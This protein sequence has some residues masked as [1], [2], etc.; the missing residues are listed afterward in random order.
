MS[1][2]GNVENIYPLSPMQEGML[3]HTLYAPESGAYLRQLSWPIESALDLEA[4]HRAWSEVV[5]RHPILRTAFLWEGRDRPLQ[6]VRRQVRLHLERHDWRGLSATEQAARLAELLESDRR[7]SFDLVRAPLLR[8]RL[9]TLAE[10]S[11]YL[12]WSY[13]QLLLDGWSR[14]QVLREVMDLYR[15][16]VSGS[17]PSL[18]LARPFGE[19]IAWLERQDRS[20][21]E[22]YWRQSLQG[23]TAPMPLPF[24]RDPED[25]TGEREGDGD[26][27]L[28]LAVAATAALKA[29]AR[30][31]RLTLNAAVQGAWS[32]LLSRYSGEPEVLFGVTVSG[33]PADLPG[34][35]SMVGLFINTLPLRV[36]VPA[37][38][39][40][41][42]WLRR[43]QDRQSEMRQFEYSPLVDIQG[44]SEVPRGRAL[45]D[46]IMVFENYLAERGP[47]GSQ[48]DGLGIGNVRSVEWLGFP[49]ILVAGPGERLLLRV[50]YESQ[51]FDDVAILRL[52]RHLEALLVAF[53]EDPERRLG[54]LDFLG[55]GERHQL[56]LEWNDS[57]ATED[58]A[59]GVLVPS[60]FDEQAVRTPDR[61]AL[62]CGEEALTY[63]ALRARVDETALRLQR[64][65]V[66]PDVPVGLFLDRSPE[67]VVGLLGVLK[68]G[69]AY[70]SLDPDLPI[71]RLIY[72]LRDSGL[73]VVLTT[74][75]LRT[76]VPAGEGCEVLCL[77]AGWSG[78]EKGPASVV[79]EGHLAYLIYTSGT[80]GRPK[81]VM[82][83]HRS[84]ANVLLA[85]RRRFGW[86]AG[87]R[88]PVL[89]PSSFDIFLFELLNPLLAGG[90]CD[91]IPLK[92]VLDLERLAA[93]LTGATRFHAVPALM[94][95]I[96]DQARREGLE[97]EAFGG[98][99]SIFVGGD[100]VPADLLTAMRETFPAEIHV[101]YG[102]TEGTVICSSFAV[103]PAGRLRGGLIGRPLEN[104]LLRV[105]D[106]HE[107]PASVGVPGELWI[108][109]AGVARG[110]LGREELTAEKYLTREGRRYYRTG[111][112]VRWLP[113]GNLEFLGRVDQQVKIRGFRVEPGEIEA[114]LREHP[115]VAEAAVVASGDP[116][117]Y[118]R[119]L[120]YVVP[121][122]DSK[123]EMELWPSSGEYFVYDE[124]TYHGLTHDLRR[125]EGYLRALRRHVAGKV[126]VDVG[127]GRDAIQARLCIEAGAERVYAIEIVEETC[128]QA[129]KCIHAL[130]LSDRI[131]VIHGNALEVE[132][133]ERVDVCVSEIVE[134]IAG[135]EGAAII[136]NGA[137]RFL[138]DG[139]VMIPGRCQTLIAAAS[140][141]NELL[142][143]PRF[144]EVSGHYVEMIFE[145][146]GH[147]F[148]LRL[149]IK[150]FPRSRL[151]ST[152]GV[153]EDLDF[154]GP[155]DVEYSRELKL[156]VERPGRMDGFLAWLHMELVPGEVIDILE[157]PYSWLPVYFPVFHP[158]IEV[159]EGDEIRAICRG[160]LSENGVNPDYSLEGSIVG[161]GGETLDFRF[162]SRRYEKRYK[163]TP[164]YD[165]L[166]R[167]GPVP[168]RRRGPVSDLAPALKGYLG[169]RLPEYMV[170]SAFVELA[171]LPLTPHGKVDRRALAERDLP[172]T[173]ER[174]AEEAPRNWIEEI[175]VSTW[176]QVLGR[177]PVGIH[178]SFFDLGGHSLL[179]TQAISRLRESFRL[180]LPLA[181]LFAAPSVAGF[182]RR[183]ERELE[184]GS[185]VSAPPIVPVPRDRDLPLSFA[186]QRLWFLHE[187]EPDSPVY[188]VPITLR[189]AGNLDR[190]VL[191][192]SLSEVVRRHEVL[193][194]TFEPRASGAVQVIAPPGSV[195]L[196]LVDLCCLVPE[197]RDGEVWHLARE[198]AR[199]PLNL[200]HGPLLRIALL[201]LAPFEHVLL[202][203]LHHV[204]CDGW[205]IGILVRELAAL[206]GA[207]VEGRAAR[208]PELPVQYAD[209]ALWQ[210]EWLQG[211]VL[212]DLL[213]YWTRQLGTSPAMLDLPTDRPRPAVQT[214]R[215]A[216]RRMEL[217]A[218]LSQ[219]LYDL[220]RRESTTP[221]M[222]LLAVYATLLG[223][224][225]VQD[226]IILGTPI[227]GRNRAEIEGL[228]GF[229]VNT[230]ALRIDLGGN[231]PFR[232]LAA[233]VREVALGAY[234]GQD[235]PFDR[236]VEELGL[237]RDLG[238][239]PLF[240]T[241][242]VLQ[243]FPRQSFELPALELHAFP[244][245]GETAKL[246]LTLSMS[247]GSEGIAGT[248][249]YST[250][251]FDAATAE[252]LLGH[253]RMLLEAAV[254]DPLARLSE[255]SMMSGL[256][257]HQLLVE[258]N[259]SPL[260]VPVRPVHELFEMQARRTPDAPAVVFPG[261]RLSYAQLD[262]RADRLAA[263]LGGR[264][265]APGALVA[266]SAERS[267]DMIVALLGILKAG[268]AYVPLDPSYP[269]ERLELMI[270][271]SQANLLVTQRAL[272][273]GLLAG[274]I[275]LMLLEDEREADAER[276]SAWAGM[277]AL[278][279][280]AYVVY[281]SGSTGRPKGILVSHG[282]LATRVLA[283][284]ETYG[285]GPGRRMLQFL[286][287]SFDAV[288]EEIYP[289]LVSGG[290]L[291]MLGDPAAIPPGE[292]LDRAGELGA[293]SFHVPPSYWYQILD[294]FAATGRNIPEHV[295]LFLTGGESTLVDKL[296]AWLR[297]SRHPHRFFNVYGPSEATIS[298]TVYQVPQDA[299][300]VARLSRL[301]IGRVVPY[302]A[303]YVLSPDGG[304][305]P[306]G[307]PG[308]L[309]LGDCLADGYLGRPDLTAERFV[310][311]PVGPRGDRLYRTGDL[312][313]RL[314]DGHLEY[315]GRLDF[316]V[317]IRGFRVELG[318]IEAA[319]AAHPGVRQAAVTAGGES[320]ERRLVAYVVPADGEQPA[321][322]TLRMALRQRLPEH[323]VPGAFVML[324]ALPLTP[325]GKVDRRSLPPVAMTLPEREVEEDESANPIVQLISAIWC[326]VL[327]IERVG[328]S[329]DFFELGGHSLLAMQVMSRLRQAFGVDLALRALFESPTVLALARR[330]EAALQ[331]RT[332]STVPPLSRVPRAHGEALPLS[333]AQQRLWFLDQLEPG[334]AAYNVG[335]A[336]RLSGEL[337]PG[338]LARAL[339]AVARRHESL[340]TGFSEVSGEPV[341]VIAAAAAVELPL[342]DLESLSSW[343]RRREMKR[344]VS[345]EAG[346]PFDL[347]RAPL[348][349]A[350]L[351]QIDHE[352]HVLV[353]TMHHIV[354]D[355]WSVE[356]L[357]REVAAIYAAF[358]AGE[359]RPP[360]P[361]L[362]L[363]YADF[364][365]WQRGWLAGGV[366]AREI[367]HWRAELAGLAPVLELPADRPR[368]AI[369][370]VRGASV[371]VSLPRLLGLQVEALGR[372]CG[373]TRF[374][375]LLSAFEVLL[376]R[377]AGVTDFAVG[378]PI[379]GRSREE[380]EGLIGFFVNTMVLRADVG[381]EPT[382][383]ELVG[384]VRD[385]VLRAHAHQDL[386]FEKLVEELEPERSLSHTPLFQVMFLLQQQTTRRPSLVGLAAQPL[387]VSVQS[388]KFDLTLRLGGGAETL[389]GSFEYRTDL[390]DCT[391]IERMALHYRRLL[392]ALA[393]DPGLRISELPLLGGAERFQL[394]VA[395]NDIAA[396][397]GPAMCLHELFAEQAV[398]TPD[399]NAVVSAGERLSY[400]ELD[401]RAEALASKLRSLGVGPE[402]RVGVSLE[403]TAALAVG[404]LGIL[405][406]GGAYVPLDPGHPRE[407]L[408]FLLSD[409][410]V[411]VWVTERQVLETLPVAAVP[412]VLMEDEEQGGGGRGIS[413]TGV[414]VHPENLA[415][416]IYT[417]GSTGMPKAVAV[418]HR[419]AVARMRWARE[420]FDADELSGVLASTPIGFDLSVFELFVPL[421]WGGKVVVVP[422]LLDLPRL[423][424]MAEVRLV[425]TVPSLLS[426]L[427][428][429]SSLP[430]SVMAVSL[431][432]EA[433]P[434]TLLERLRGQD[435]L[436]RVRNLYGPSEDTTYSTM[437]EV[438]GAKGGTVPIGRPLPGSVAHVLSASGEPVPPGVIGELY[439]GGAG[440]SRGYLGR[441]ELT[442][443]RFVPDGLSG[444]TGSRLYRTGDRVRRLAEG[445][446][447]FLG[448]IDHQVK[449]RG[450]RVELGEVESALGRHPDISESVVV[451]QGES[452]ERVL[453]AYVVGREGRSP[454][455][456]ELRDFL[457][458][459]VPAALIPSLF[460]ALDSLPRTS[461]GKVDRRALPA[462][463]RGRRDREIE[464]E[465]GSPVAQV[466]SAIWSDVLGIDRIGLRESF[467]ELGGHSLLATRVISRVRQA[468]GVEL[469]LRVL[470]EEPTVLALASRVEKALQVGGKH[471]APPLSR[472]PRSVGETMPLSFGQQRLWFL[473]QLEPGGAGFNMPLAA[474][475]SGVL[476]LA[477]LESAFNEVVRRHET[478]RTTF[479]AVGGEPVQ[480][481]A[482]W[483]ASSL[484]V[485]D[486]SGL[487]EN[488]RHE[489]SLALA[490]ADAE[491]PF[492]L[493]H[494]PLHRW[495][496]LRLSASEHM[497]L[498]AL[499]HSVADGWSL[500]VLMREIA[501]LYDAFSCGLPSPL[502]ELAIQYA[503]YARW[504]RGWLQGETLSRELDHWRR[505][506]E[507]A[508][509]ILE[510]P[511]DRPRPAV[512]SSRGAACSRAFSPVLSLA[513]RN[514]GRERSVTPFMLSL[515][516]FQ[517]LLARYSGQFDISV[518]APIAGRN[519][520]ETEGLIGLFLNVLVLRSDLSL[521]RF[522]GDLLHRVRDE[523]LSAYA[524]QDL[525]FELLVEELKPERTLSHAPLF[526]VMLIF[527]NTPHSRISL[528]GLTITRL[529]SEKRATAVDLTLHLTA[530]DGAMTAAL[531]YSTDLFVEA[532]AQR[533]LAHLEV[534]LESVVAEPEG[535]V[536]DLPLVTK[537]E[538]EQVVTA[539]N[540]TQ[541]ELPAEG[542]LDRIGEWVERQPEAVAVADGRERLSYGELWRRSD[543]VAAGLLGRGLELEGVVALLAPRSA[544]Y[545]TVLLAIWKAGG[546]YLPLDPEHPA[547]RMEEMLEQSGTQ[548][549]VSA[550]P[551]HEALE[552]AFRRLSHRVER[553][554]LP[555]LEEGEASAL[556]FPRSEGLAYMIFTSGSTG[557]PKGAMVEH[558]GMLNHLW[559]K[560]RDLGLGVGDVVA[561]TAS[562]SFDISVWQ[563]LAALLAGGRVEVVSE[564]EAREP[565]RLLA[566]V[567]G[568]G[569]TVLELVPSMLGFLLEEI[570]RQG[571]ER[572]PLSELRFMMPTGE[573]LSAELCRR[574]LAAYPGVALV[575]AYGPTECSDDVTHHV[576][577]QATAVGWESV[578]IGAALPNLRLYV[579]D[580]GGNLVPDGISGELWVGG[581]GVGRGY[582][583]EPGQTAAAF[584]PDGFSG[585]AGERLYCTGDRVR[586]R[587]GEGVLEYLGRLD[588][589]VKLRGFRVELGEIEAVLA[590][591]PAVR[592]SAVVVQH[593]K[594]EPRLIAYV[595]GEG[596]PEDRELQSWL[597]QRL[598]LPMVPTA[599]VRLAAL[600]LTPNGKLDRR[601]L[602]VPALAVSPQGFEPP[603][604]AAEELVC[605]V[606]T[607][608]LGIERVGRSESFFELGG[609]SLLATQVMSR[610]RQAFGIDLPLS[611][612][613]EEPTVAGLTA[614]LLATSN[615]GTGRASASL[616]RVPRD[617]NLPLSFNQQ[618]L[619]FLD[620]LE[621]GSSSYNLP[622]ALRINGPLS[623]RVLA[624]VLAEV[625]RR[626][627][628]LRTGFVAIDG[629]PVQMIAPSVPVE[630]P[631]IDLSWLPERQRAAELERLRR[632]E[633][634][635]V[636]DL[637]RAPLLRAALLRLA[638]QDH[639]GLFTMHHIVSDDWSMRL[640]ESEVAALY[641]AFAA[642]R[643]SPLPE[644]TLQYADYASWQRSWLAGEVL[645]EH[646][647]YWAEQLHGELPVLALPTDYLRPASPSERGAQASFLL[648][649]QLAR[650]LVFLSRREGVTLF[651]TLLAG[652][653]V[654]LNRYTG[655]QD[656]IVGTAI[657][658][659]DRREIEN[660]IG[661]FINM[662][663]LRVDLSAVATFRDLLRMVR[664]V[665]LGAYVHQ[666]L[667]FDKLVQEL[668]PARQGTH[669]PIFQVAFGLRNV[670]ADDV[671]LKGLS[672]R[673]Q[674]AEEAAVRFDL[675][676][677]MSEVSAGLSAVWRYR[678]D[679]FAPATIAR[680]NE[681]LQTLL[682]SAAANPDAG[683]ADLEMRSG[684][685]RERRRR[686]EEVAE[687][688]SYRRFKSF[689]R[690]KPA[691]SAQ[692]GSS[693]AD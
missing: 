149:C 77:D 121:A 436:R 227:A 204:V 379:A 285:L 423:A 592:Q 248:L 622:L 373:A 299:D 377:H 672:L 518:G 603:L 370:S 119:L 506:L 170:P 216:Y 338:E 602:P 434:E 184:A 146:A 136:L 258:W 674:M 364:A 267:P 568:R 643:P 559:G 440:L 581:A 240:Q 308:E 486:L 68:S 534:L 449:V 414:R 480:R 342:I 692:T 292:L 656:L 525:P 81:A 688:A 504:Q 458:S 37:D 141:P 663:P 383:G 572:P 394:L 32:L 209:F 104:V 287:L 196:P 520:L 670:P 558:R 634:L 544:S 159:K 207:L 363:Q 555:E 245:E 187:M 67:L 111:D 326:D 636:F 52:L 239:Q 31:H 498:V 224:Y 585:C 548:L 382:V 429:S 654:L 624:A 536:W 306:V 469:A 346:R 107:A 416:L 444:G 156:A 135:A 432:G 60:L 173:S 169:E 664:E 673:P 190:A 521:N 259:G 632:E 589:Q 350:E 610:L 40:L 450:L 309:H 277:A 403:R 435:S 406:A 627:E 583:G 163:A 453:V 264:A 206:Y 661:L 131:T 278:E 143:D 691:P 88:L 496:L 160:A 676:L 372:R 454:G 361:E 6:V 478:L 598:P 294:H 232:Q 208:P 313:R 366:L 41:V 289:V 528:P 390:F 108:G 96:V 524:H 467:F 371:M 582:V 580:P 630:L 158:G 122:K 113:D 79:E 500:D 300:A 268:C 389:G 129:R 421:S 13:P 340:R 103:P 43:L 560:V 613:F 537:A 646:L 92:P 27:T 226:E 76:A 221:F 8:L 38:E 25:Q 201:R 348:L 554:S 564:E 358:C 424:E 679:L 586:R 482:P 689:A 399:A 29:F 437:A 642:E 547:R 441:P 488:R 438:G 244:V 230:L 481:V 442:A 448:R 644:L 297:A 556:S 686:E 197:A 328:A 606:W 127:T 566:A 182:A 522:F 205:S 293:D 69:G 319:L 145:Q 597:R 392:E 675:T 574:W 542:L 95:Q 665:A 157:E 407:R 18:A 483:R 9:V 443:E 14:A 495:L 447:A 422:S 324:A 587:A 191:S 71:E 395:W 323:M 21:A 667:P 614:K 124:L 415:Y 459:V 474:R 330:V 12:V 238:R 658:G 645:D 685:E 310:P 641:S 353:L 479:P 329:E 378:T 128:R 352:E 139:G 425:N 430:D 126:V 178:D 561:Q 123:G 253:F 605:N 15:A 89:A 515:A 94:A 286:S 218:A 194:T 335:T 235:L 249:S 473:D 321:A 302:S 339:L 575:N 283:L 533:M 98:L 657:A 219:S 80:T 489:E 120:A 36:P 22:A 647:A 456:S 593:E 116:S 166:F 623:V 516:A 510:L 461:H 487:P 180:E 271:D 690:N 513:L 669:T 241:M 316:Q 550:R 576:V 567:A 63:G 263:R 2:R 652:F 412:L 177:S 284:A 57:P 426:E 220:S 172:A 59:G 625:V 312:A 359:E 681:H 171:S 417:S 138:R 375:I 298:A 596:L 341:Q 563:F 167:E 595:A 615:A 578:P 507:G 465:S 276:R 151:L 39:P 74:R 505:R 649:A 48:D 400:R 85:S 551:S 270:A 462:A 44:W 539:W 360:L 7:T 439:L 345:Q 535:G 570:E 464:E 387:R 246:D 215:G 147:P 601:A 200:A 175:L 275:P 155:A 162:D 176:E 47:E 517:V 420:E 397:E 5:A 427:L 223:R 179:A 541:W 671:P 290:A 523:T 16:F 142:R 192:A 396:A 381:G 56:L 10:R 222:T 684:A 612:L 82:V 51:R 185:G 683:L 144:T 349:R 26:H 368:P 281:T 571:S 174:E 195:D 693:P 446:L 331:L 565:H 42:A 50:A 186:Q 3:F 484:P 109:G 344:L 65:G 529:R 45:F 531:E 639:L 497:V 573:A 199:R 618:R 629:Q 84:L 303:A 234:A 677:W 519:H 466:V 405:K 532:T 118:R 662:L 584:V 260:A 279:D 374:M 70:V 305:S 53:A 476:E 251:L 307:V 288:G 569:V 628:I 237:G 491:R 261:G 490:A 327:G 217:P 181:A 231:P 11:H 347:Q 19:Y 106:R 153:F 148:D 401:R 295:E 337:H 540:Q 365:A 445:S 640:L 333:F 1:R 680:M 296:A 225:A 455:A 228:I 198:E 611:A 678:S 250:D 262:E 493:A 492:D 557:R 114:V 666:E 650:D 413:G 254:R 314:P 668:Q 402:V 315:L 274:R 409:A 545:L 388:A 687:E 101:L 619:W 233:R 354:T 653:E 86:S 83:E 164:F 58:I 626:H 269:R 419:S 369:Q 66:G 91:L 105:V 54:S 351:L 280:P 511:T 508:S 635:R 404:L 655:Q 115:S 320:G 189:L 549:V 202:G 117:G 266:V 411:A 90:T 590:T 608:V 46:S 385:A 273:G 99:R 34:V 457:R 317:K 380:L 386:P 398:R 552:E 391:T 356:V 609:H 112:R 322:V 637:R 431:A 55:E 301:P 621:P 152:T 509:P 73:W 607:E 336:L 599:L 247:T 150:G 17:E 311:N 229:F 33:R 594:A 600:P 472:A 61:V 20:R 659:R 475:L 367:E 272:A 357:L 526:Q 140:L 133:P 638:E 134:A 137:R 512:Q 616:T 168:V 212:A 376:W 384:R 265:M 477:A 355:G 503:D 211:K 318:E 588:Q 651:M 617:G 433:L 410:E 538:R 210:R 236:L 203:T 252:R 214:F 193:R 591:H 35:E 460:V 30:A 256:E 562:Q 255:L 471:A 110:Y 64:L 485:A 257:R 93:S 100:T 304:Q 470:F 23:L 428:R 213:A 418:E 452:A 154:C 633:A 530:T 24:E 49:L 543:R 4:L 527:Q 325:A 463:S 291:V 97:P 408:A 125:N 334:S 501:A 161:R 242:F 468:F 28:L 631:L 72:T 188:N 579:V 620:Q 682:E 282:A 499:H 183:V 553:V 165:F 502:P 451:L 362:P 243:N 393:A 604:G 514:L 343:H 132:L 660:L 130:G 87:D 78:V 102:P 494:G 75:G 62:L 577:S 332:P 648:P 546:V